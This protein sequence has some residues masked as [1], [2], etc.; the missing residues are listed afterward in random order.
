MVHRLMEKLQV[1]KSPDRAW[2]S[3]LLYN[4]GDVD[5]HDE[6]DE[7]DQTV[8]N[9]AGVDITCLSCRRPHHGLEHRIQPRGLMPGE[10]VT[11][12]V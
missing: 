10:L 6:D 4:Q 5:D 12:S 7:E 3:L 1:L 11:S 9:R 2:W 8:A